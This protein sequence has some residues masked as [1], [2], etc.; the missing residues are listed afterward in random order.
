MKRAWDIQFG[1]NWW[2]SFGFHLD[3]T[4][5]SLTLHLPLIVICVDLL[6]E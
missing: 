1:D 6:H 4:D 2:L 3:H 5:P